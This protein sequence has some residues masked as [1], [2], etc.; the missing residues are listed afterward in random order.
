VPTLTILI[1]FVLHVGVYSLVDLGDP[2]PWYVAPLVMHLT[3]LASVGVGWILQRLGRWASVLGAACALASLGAAPLAAGSDL[4]SHVRTDLARLVAGTWLRAHAAPDE[5]V[6]T[7]NGLSAFAFGGPVFD[8]SGLNSRADSPLR[9]SANYWIIE[10]GAAAP[11][12]SWVLVARFRLAEAGD[13]PLARGGAIGFEVWA[14]PDSRI[15]RSGVGHG[16]EGRTDSSVDPAAV[17]LTS[18]AWRAYLE[19]RPR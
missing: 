17:P 11:E 19:A 12:G 2:Y 7:Y 6:I 10:E 14:H 3:I 8:P 15:A 1:W 9:A 5:G 4:P 13:P 16:V 18:R